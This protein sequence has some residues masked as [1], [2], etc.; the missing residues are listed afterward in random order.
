MNRPP[1]IGLAL[2]LGIGLVLAIV[3]LLP[4]NE[5]S[6]GGK[7]LTY[8]TTRLVA[9]NSPE[10]DK[11]R[12][13]IRGIGE[14]ALPFLLRDLSAKDSGW[15]L[16][17][18]DWLEHQSLIKSR[19]SLASNRRTRAAE[20]MVALGPEAKSGI[21]ELVQLIRRNDGLVNTGSRVLCAVGTD[22]TRQALSLLADTNVNLRA[23]GASSLGVLIDD[24]ERAV[25]ALTLLLSD[26]D[27]RVR[28]IAARALGS[29]GTNSASAVPELTKLL[30][31][32]ETAFDAAYSL[33]RVGKLGLPALESASVSTNR[34]T[35]TAAQTALAGSTTA[36]KQS[37][38]SSESFQNYQRE[39]SR[40]NLRA[41]QT[42][43]REQKAGATLATNTRP[44]I[45]V[46][47]PENA[48][49]E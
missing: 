7:S 2:G 42:R 48:N 37:V 31:D 34:A 47:E 17:V 43:L 11:A 25:P 18:N 30:N 21:T 20:A 9:P 1:W 5:P 41:I 23:M 12:E 15:K 35:R 38:A 40:F 44:E 27:K 28:S 19:F 39:K 45:A 24:P 3:F 6:H 33:E 13:A 14:D 10:V 36:P 46:P 26:R 16:K 8:W 32:A 4:S 49:K 22:A 29:Y